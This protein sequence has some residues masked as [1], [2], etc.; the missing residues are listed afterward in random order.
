VP[1]TA[2]AGYTP[3]RRLSSEQFRNTVRDL[4]KMN[5]ADVRTM[6]VTSALPPD[7]SIG[8]RFTSNITSP[9]Q[10]IGAEQYFDL[11]KSLADKA[12][13]NLA[14][15]VP[16]VPASGN[17]TCAQQ[18]IEGFGKRAFRRP[19]TPIEVERY[20]KVYTAGGDFTNGIRLVLWTLLQ[21]PNFLYIV[22]AVPANGAGKLLALDSYSVASRLSYFF[23][24]SMP[25][26]ALFA[27]ADGNKLTTPDQVAQQ[28]TR[29]L[30]DARFKD[31]S[32]LFHN[33]WLELGLV[34]S[35]D[36]DAA[37]F[38]MWNEALQTALHEQSK[39]FAEGVIF[40]GDGRAETLLTSTSYFMSGPL[41]ALYGLPA[42]AGAAANTW[43]KV[44]VKPTE[45]AG[46]L[47]HAGLM[48]GQ[49][50]EN[51]TSFILRGKLV[52]EAI[53]CGEVPPPPENVNTMEVN[54]SP[55]ASARERSAAHR[56]KPE[57][58]VCHA[59][60]DPIGFAFERYDA[61]GRYRPTDG[62]GRAID[63]TA[64]ISGTA[65]LNGPVADAIDLAKKVGASEELRACVAK[66]WLRFALGRDVDDA[67]DA[68][69][70]AAAL[71]TMNDTNGKVTD[72]LVTLA[73]SD[74]FRHLKV[75]P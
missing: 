42:P 31:A 72:M 67:E 4:L 1:G 18:F 14:A 27:A 34:L 5:A 53:L 56:T 2:N 21:S 73:R 70:L 58:A 62:M 33:E 10:P 17:A 28:A 40:G 6:V 66:Q 36:K 48:A 12:V 69:S 61:V 64:D 7:D 65:K 55:N 68:T 11:A 75:K 20:K 71:K 24:G 41:Y 22:E 60:F 54:V 47:T 9:V 15:L 8:E 39:R 51:R 35:G 49:A 37:L 13:T 3:L 44:D 29:L 52:R 63:A 23:L 26:D 74:A 19:L 50:H 38:P 32:G 43:T 30:A 46:L 57:C 45:R 59:L 16:C 25:D